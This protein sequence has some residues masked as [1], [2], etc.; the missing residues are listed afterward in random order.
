VVVRVN[1]PGGSAL[2]SDTLHHELMRLRA[3]GKKVVVR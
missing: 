1:S 2:A 3:A